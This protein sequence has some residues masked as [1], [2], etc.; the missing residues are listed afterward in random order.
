MDK[1]FILGFGV[2]KQGMFDL[3]SNL[4]S[5][6]TET[7]ANI[8]LDL[9]LPNRVKLVFG[10]KPS[11][12]K[13]NSI[14]I[15]T[16][17]NNELDPLIENY[18]LANGYTEKLRSIIPVLNYINK[19]RDFT[20]SDALINNEQFK[21]LIRQINKHNSSTLSNEAIRNY[22]V[23][24]LQKICGDIRHI[25]SAQSPID[26][27]LDRIKLE[28]AKLPGRD[29][30]SAY[31]G[32][33]IYQL[34]EDNLTG[35]A[36]VGIM[37]NAIKAFFSMTQ[38]FNKY[39]ADHKDL[40]V[41]DNT[42]FVNK[43][44]LNGKEYN[45]ATV[46]NATLEQT[47][48]HQLATILAQVAGIDS[49]LTTDDDVSIIL[50]S[51][52]SLATDNAKEL[53]LSKMHA[54]LNLA[55]MHGYLA[56]FG[57]PTSDIVRYTTSPLFTR[58]YELTQAN[59]YENLSGQINRRIWEQL[60]NESR[61]AREFTEQDVLDLK[62][63]YDLAQELRTL[64]SL[65]S[66]NQG[67]KSNISNTLSFVQV[68]KNI[69]NN[70]FGKLRDTKSDDQLI[71]SII[72]MHGLV[73]NN[74]LINF[75]SQK[76]QQVKQLSQKYDDSVYG[77]IKV[78]MNKYFTDSEY[79]NYIIQAYDL[80]KG[81]V[82]VFSIIN[83]LPHFY[84]MLRAFN[85]ITQKL[86]TSAKAEFI[87][88]SDSYFKPLEIN[89][90]EKVEYFDEATGESYT[91][92]RLLFKVDYGY[93]DFVIG[94]LQRFYD[95]YVLSDYVKNIVPDLFSISYVRNINGD[96]QKKVDVNFRDSDSIDSFK[97]LTFDLLSKLKQLYPDNKFLSSLI[98]VNINVGQD[99]VADYRY[100]LNFNLDTLNSQNSEY[101][102]LK[103]NQI[104]G[105]FN[106]IINLKIKNILNN[107]SGS[108]SSVGDALYLYNTIFNKDSFGQN[109]LT[110]LFGKYITN[111]N[112]LPLA[113][114]KLEQEYEL[115][116]KEIVTNSNEVNYF[117][118]KNRL[119]RRLNGEMIINGVTIKNISPLQNMETIKNVSDSYI[120]QEQFVEALKSGL[121]E[122]NIGDC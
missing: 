14:F 119:P 114:F 22:T 11:D 75:Y 90:R 30:G 45:I 56:M 46:A 94:Q 113:K 98:P 12:Y 80:I 109:S 85:T 103:Y 88:S 24:Q 42:F 81:T 26:E 6:E 102:Q 106:D 120:A 63:L 20:V 50:S 104:V 95:D 79:Q 29:N 37:A 9:P 92:N 77:N 111:K 48:I 52:V 107:V 108:D 84:E 5:L 97:Q 4:G 19:T 21:Y 44:H 16:G 58:L 25:Q 10:N 122:I 121:L 93:T 83:S 51:L 41:S 28:I 13:E 31:D 15:Q 65:L 1:A 69:Y 110:R 62:N 67:V 40:S 115:R 100:R 17:E 8:S 33:S 105:G 39:Y 36:V 117:I 72:Q 53:A 64:T 23:T 87:L 34:Q 99:Q 7:L 91:E 2:N 49:F 60:L 3:W 32:K 89:N 116:Q 18:I 68:F 101:D 61:F 118:F 59:A 57:I 82:N 47:Q 74:T 78:D 71:N 43:L 73:P 66:I 96:I 70:Q 112:V 55:S 86:K 38:Y 35:K 27:A 76:L 54:S